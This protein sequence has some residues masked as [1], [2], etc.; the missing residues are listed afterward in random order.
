MAARHSKCKGSL[1]ACQ[2]PSRG[3]KLK[4]IH[5]GDGNGGRH[6]RRVSDIVVRK[7]GRDRAIGL[8]DISH[9]GRRGGVSS[10]GRRAMEGIGV[11]GC[12]EPDHR[13]SLHFHIDGGW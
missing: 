5:T 12:D 11:G 1:S 4:R 7:G 2:Y 8:I 13:C 6:R 9:N 3:R 10:A